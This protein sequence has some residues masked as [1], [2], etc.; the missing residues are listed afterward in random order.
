MPRARLQ[1]QRLCE[2]F[3]NL[4]NELSHNT[5]VLQPHMERLSHNIKQLQGHSVT[6]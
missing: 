6:C 1:P 5:Q 4:L 2:A 3:E